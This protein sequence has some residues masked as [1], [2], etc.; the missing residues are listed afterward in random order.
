M[1]SFPANFAPVCDLATAEHPA[2]GNAATRRIRSQRLSEREAHR[3]I[4]SAYARLSDRSVTHCRVITVDLSRPASVAAIGDGVLVD[5]AAVRPLARRRPHL[6][7]CDDRRVQVEHV[8]AI[9][10]GI[11]GALAVLGGAE[12]IVFGLGAEHQ[13]DGDGMGLTVRVCG[14]LAW[15]GLLVEGGR[16]L[17]FASDGGRISWEDSRV[18]AWVVR[19]STEAGPINHEASLDASPLLPFCRLPAGVL[20]DDV[21]PVSRPSPMSNQHRANH[22][23][24]RGPSEAEGGVL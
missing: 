17:A 16:D 4:L 19:I 3:A 21:V 13:G 24:Q 5:C 23:P 18:Q 22:L 14:G 1:E 12:T 15:C 2:Q 6:L 7:S 11:G 10:K 20:L 9:R 8:A